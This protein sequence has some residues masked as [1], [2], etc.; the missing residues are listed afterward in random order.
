MRDER[1]GKMRDE[2]EGEM[3]DEREGETTEEECVNSVGITPPVFS[4]PPGKPE[5]TL[6]DIQPSPS[7]VWLTLS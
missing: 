6:C 5:T 1:E 4:V 3:K 2:R 7:R